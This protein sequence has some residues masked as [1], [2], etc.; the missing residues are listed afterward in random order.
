[1]HKC[2]CMCYR[3][4]PFLRDTNFAN[5]AEKAVHGKNDIGGACRPLHNKH[6]LV[7][8]AYL[9]V[10]E[11][12][13]GLINSLRKD[14]AVTEFHIFIESRDCLVLQ[15]NKL[16]AAC[17]SILISSWSESWRLHE[18]I[19]WQVAICEQGF[20]IYVHRLG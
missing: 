12:I 5:G 2:S 8:G 9:T 11:D 19:D 10:Q 4:A 6:E 14:S 3:R 18:T 13:L 20:L 7:W 15:Q 16:H 17:V 1:M